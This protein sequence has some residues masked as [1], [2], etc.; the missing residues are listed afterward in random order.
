M[1]LH[2]DDPELDALLWTLFSYWGARQIELLRL[3]PENVNYPRRSVVLEGKFGKVREMP[4]PKPVLRVA[5][6]GP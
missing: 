4:L 1:L 5:G 2:S 3:R 6:I